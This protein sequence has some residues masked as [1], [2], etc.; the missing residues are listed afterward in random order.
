M[1][2]E[3]INRFNCQLTH[4]SDHPNHEVREYGDPYHGHGESYYIPVKDKLSKK[5]WLLKVL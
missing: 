5:K 3:T 1:L 4:N 2:W